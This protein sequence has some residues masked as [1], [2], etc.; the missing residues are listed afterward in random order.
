VVAEA[1]EAA[2]AAATAE[3]MAVR[4]PA[5]RTLKLREMLR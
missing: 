4:R 2:V 1:A 3:G 5:V